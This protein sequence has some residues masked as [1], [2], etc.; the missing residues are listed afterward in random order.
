MKE[1][2]SNV[3]HTF[4]LISFLLTLAACKKEVQPSNSE[5]L[6]LSQPS[7]TDVQP[8]APATIKTKVLTNN[9]NFPW[10]I[11]WGADAVYGSRKEVD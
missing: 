7:K 4:L 10:E 11:I 8:L 2:N 6:L 9:L 3:Y 1:R 5:Q